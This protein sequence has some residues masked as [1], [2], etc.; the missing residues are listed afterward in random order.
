VRLAGSLTG[1]GRAADAMDVLLD[2]PRHLEVDHRLDVVHVE[3]ARG[4]PG[5]DED[6]D[7]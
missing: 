5:G 2:R 4:Q 6:V 7:L 1:A 3:A